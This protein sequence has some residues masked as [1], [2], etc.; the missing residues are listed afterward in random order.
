MLIGAYDKLGTVKSVSSVVA[1]AGLVAIGPALVDA[2]SLTLKNEG[3]ARLGVDELATGVLTASGDVVTP[4]LPLELSHSPSTV[5]SD[6]AFVTGSS[7]CLPLS[8][9]GG[10]TLSRIDPLSAAG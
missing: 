5:G 7:R 6:D 1:P 2:P 3:P 10:G 9:R 4:A 8:G